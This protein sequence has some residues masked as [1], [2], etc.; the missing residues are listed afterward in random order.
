MPRHA[1]SAT[2]LLVLLATALPAGLSGQGFEGRVTLE[3]S[4]G[5]GRPANDAV[6]LVKGTKTRLEMAAPGMPGMEVY[7]IMDEESGTV[8]SV[9][10]SQ[11]MYVTMD[12][13]KAAGRSSEGSK[14]PKITR[15]GRTEKIAGISCEHVL[16]DEGGGEQMDVCGASGMGFFGMRGKHGP[17]GGGA[18]LPPGYAELAREFKDGFFPLTVDR[19]RGGS[20]ERM[21]TVKSIERKPLDQALFEPPTGFRRMDMPQGPP[22]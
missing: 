16:L 2:P 12:A 17:M 22:M 7:M 1:T 9:M 19:V 10:P 3:I 6:V 20:R 21:V 14:A 5:A 4:G 8:I 18:A 13:L 15:T 11:R